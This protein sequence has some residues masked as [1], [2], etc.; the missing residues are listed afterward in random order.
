MQ[1]DHQREQYFYDQPTRDFL[2]RVV[3][4]SKRPVLLCAPTLGRDLWEVHRRQVPTLDIDT[5]FSDLPGFVEWDIHR[6][7]ALDFKPDLVLCDPPFH[8]V[9]LDRL[10]RAITTLTQGDVT[11]PL[12][13]S[14]LYRR[15]TALLGTFIRFGLQRTPYEPTYISVRPEVDIRMYA[16]QGT[17]T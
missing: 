15:E 16:S 5:R 14:W 2:S 6:P 4:A 3:L 8:T 1:E 9:K 11:V 13:L 10:Y 17:L 12:V 7:T